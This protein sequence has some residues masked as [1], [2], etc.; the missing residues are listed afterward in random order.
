[1]KRNLAK[2]GILL[3]P[4]TIMTGCGNSEESQI[5]TAVE[6]IEPLSLDEVASK[7]ILSQN[8]EER[9]AEFTELIE[10]KKVVNSQNLSKV[11]TKDR[12]AIIDTFSKINA[13]LTGAP[14]SEQVITNNQFSDNYANYLLLEMA[15]TP[16]EWRQIN[17]DVLGYDPKTRL[18]FVDVTY[19]TTG[20]TKLPVPNSRI[21]LGHPDS[22]E[23][24]AKRYQEYMAFGQMRHQAETGSGVDMNQV[25]KAKR[26]F[27]NKWGSIDSILWEQQN[28]PLIERT[29]QQDKSTGGLGKLTYNGLIIN[30]KMSNLGAKMTIRFVLKYRLN[31]GEETDLYVASAYLKDYELLGA[32]KVLEQYTLKDKTTVSI[33]KPFIDRLI[34]S[35][36][37]AVEESNL[38]G[39]YSMYQNFSN[40]DKYYDEMDK[41]M[42]TSYGGYTFQ[43]LSRD[44]SDVLLKVTQSLKY[45]AKVDRKDGTE[46]SL[47][48]YIGTYLYHLVLGK[49]DKIYISSI[50]PLRKELIGEPESV[51]KN[52]TTI[53]DTIEYAKE[54]FSE[55]NAKKVNELLQKFAQ[56]VVNNDGSSDDFLAT[57]DM[58]VSNIALNRIVDT[59]KSI[60]AEREVMYVI[61]WESRT[62]TFASARVKEL[63]Q[64]K[65]VNYETESEISMVN[66]G[67][68]WKVI[69]YARKLNLTLPPKTLDGGEYGTTKP[70]ADV[71]RTDGLQLKSG[72]KYKSTDFETKVDESAELRKEEEKQAK[73][74]KAKENNQQTTEQPVQEVQEQPQEDS[75]E[76]E[77]PTGQQPTEQ[78]PVE[79]PEEAGEESEIDWEE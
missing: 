77:Q 49:D 9:A 16:Y 74:N 47:P 43:I 27:E 39:L 61:N 6:A 30:D 28:V 23:L 19:Q 46:S 59:I 75:W 64:R 7:R 55:D 63:F 24:L 25:M 67:G 50:V 12:N 31:L 13:Y 5:S 68:T 33:L 36:N 2:V 22:E 38:F 10:D 34:V 56:V 69:D 54:A 79:Q 4:L 45:R 44:G 20:N 35:Y 70:I 26:D 42:Y 32:D 14:N 41:Y 37:K 73:E 1:L 65:D 78:K 17:Q 8:L 3:L 58:G 11:A 52:V 60:Q 51:I 72:E 48:Q 18:Y 76:Q 71:K 40:W 62:N 15:N 66:R 57:V 53:S 29:R 21:P